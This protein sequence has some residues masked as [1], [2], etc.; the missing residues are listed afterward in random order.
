MD[1]SDP[2][3]ENRAEDSAERRRYWLGLPVGS[4]TEGTLE[5]VLQ[6]LPH[7]GRQPFSMASVNG[8]EIGVNPFLDM[9]YCVPLRQGDSPIP[10]G[11]VSKNYRLVDHHQVLRTAE[12]A[13]LE[14]GVK[15]SSV[16]I[17]GEW[18]V[19]GERARFSLLLPPEDR[20]RMALGVKDEIRFRIEIF[21][22]VEGSCRLMAVAGWLRFV[23]YNGLI[24]G[25]AL[26]LLRRQHRQQLLIEE[27]GSVLKQALQSTATEKETLDEWMETAVDDEVLVNWID[28]EVEQRWGI[29]AAVRVL[30]IVTHGCDVE[31]VGDLRNRRPSVIETKSLG[32]VP[33]IS[34]SVRNLFGVSQALTWIAG[35]R[36]DMAQDLEWR[37]D[38][39]HLMKTLVE[40]TNG[41]QPRHSTL[42]GEESTVLDPEN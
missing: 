18:T 20:F 28:L 26:G 13:L 24:L 30:G 33:G 8:K 17:C 42:F 6:A 21:N 15:L 2:S 5:H 12:D 39:P 16:K 37:S 25:A 14:N 36:L 11:V 41:A 38:V 19:H 10:V 4:P 3:F 22:S 23:C 35:R 40:Q 9:V 31:P 7:F 32:E 1:N 34:G 27:L 29:R